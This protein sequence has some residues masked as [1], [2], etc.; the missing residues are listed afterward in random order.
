M[1]R[2]NLELFLKINT[3]TTFKNVNLDSKCLIFLN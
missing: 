3:S 1:L 2:S